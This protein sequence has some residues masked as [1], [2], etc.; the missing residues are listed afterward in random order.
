[1]IPVYPIQP[2][3][4]ELTT[5]SVPRIIIAMADSNESKPVVPVQRSTKPV[6]EA[7]LNEKVRHKC[8]Y[9]FYDFAALP[10]SLP[11]EAGRSEY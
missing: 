2:V 3:F 1:M 6:S 10:I 5:S 8:H 4:W 11:V 7:L 9:I